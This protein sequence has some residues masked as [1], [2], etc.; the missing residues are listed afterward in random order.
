MINKIGGLKMLPLYNFLF[1]VSKV[2]FYSLII[3]LVLVTINP[4]LREQTV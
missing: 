3:F 1:D 2:S 4:L